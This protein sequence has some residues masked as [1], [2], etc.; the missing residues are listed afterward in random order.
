M[1]KEGSYIDNPVIAEMVMDPD[2]PSSE[3]VQRFTMRFPDMA[4]DITN[5]V[6]DWMVDEMFE[7]PLP[8]HLAAPGSDE[9]INSAMVRFRRLAAPRNR[10]I[11]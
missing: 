4:D 11:Y 5:F 7:S 3:V 9:A 8:P 2:F 10:I 1:A 6:T